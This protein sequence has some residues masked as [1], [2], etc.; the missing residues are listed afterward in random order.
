MHALN[1]QFDF[2]IDDDKKERKKKFSVQFVRR[3]QVFSD[4]SK[5]FFRFVIY[6]SSKVV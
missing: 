4:I 5:F 3:Y 2:W 1:T 6:N